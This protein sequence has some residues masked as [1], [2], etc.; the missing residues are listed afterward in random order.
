MLK[1]VNILPQNPNPLPLIVTVGICT[2][3]RMYIPIVPPLLLIH[4]CPIYKK[5]KIY[6]AKSIYI[7]MLE[8]GT[9]KL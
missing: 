4:L 3:V 9:I 1:A 6:T 8:Y 5:C 7:Y 2:Y